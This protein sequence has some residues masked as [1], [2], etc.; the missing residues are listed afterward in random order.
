MS[1]G[2]LRCPVKLTGEQEDQPVLSRSASFDRDSNAWTLSSYGDVHLALNE[3]NLQTAGPGGAG[4]LSPQ[5][6]AQQADVRSRT[7]AAL[8]STKLA[9]W[10][11]EFEPLAETMVAALPTAGAV[12]L[13]G[14]F[15]Q[16]WCF[17]LAV[18]MTEADPA[19]AQRL[20]ALAAQVTAAT[21]DSDNYDLKAPAAIAGKELD[22]ALRNSSQ[23]MA[24]SAFVAV[25][26]TIPCLLANAW[27]TLLSRPS[28][29]NRLRLSPELLPRV[30]EELLRVAG[31][32]KS[33]H[34]CATAD[35]AIGDIRIE[36]G[37]RVHLMLAEANHDPTQF[38]RPYDL[39]FSYRGYSHF[40]L[41]A[42]SH[43]CAAA[44]LIRMATGVSTKV[45]V[46]NFESRASNESIEWLG[47]SGFRWP[48]RLYAQRRSK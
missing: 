26:Q 20:A 41:G 48:A 33:V 7:F 28:E 8:S 42:G 24:G 22:E 46:E 30:I 6:S 19:D 36:R 16:P 18:R 15:L 23:P 25:S 37:Q 29:M 10:Q 12:E 47:G 38:P 2:T 34:R 9:Q 1:N 40:A 32:A 21:A 45:M 39:D 4:A 44:A 27:L 43:S 14:G 11:Q 31:L 13:V 3:P 5:E 17:E 35:I